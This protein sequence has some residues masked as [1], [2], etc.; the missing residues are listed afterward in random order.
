MPRIRRRS[1]RTKNQS[2]AAFSASTCP[3]V[4]SRV[5]A[6][7]KSS[8]CSRL[9]ALAIGG[10]GG[11]AAQRELAP[12]DRTVD[13]DTGTLWVTVPSDWDRADAT[14]GWRPPNADADFRRHLA[15]VLTGRA[16]L[17]AAG[18]S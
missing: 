16:V 11:Y 9:V 12:P 6:A 13:D 8:N 3:G 15:G 4:S 2:L 18:A 7:A 17:A 1:G 14:E 10:G 5:S